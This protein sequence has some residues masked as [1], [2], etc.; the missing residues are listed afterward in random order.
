MRRYKWWL[1]MMLVLH[2][3]HAPHIILLAIGTTVLAAAPTLAWSAAIFTAIAAVYLPTFRG[4]P[5]ST[6]LRSWG[7]FQVWATRVVEDAAR[8]WHGECR[9]VRDGP[10]WQFDRSSAGKAGQAQGEEEGQGRGFEAGPGE[11]GRG[12]VGQERG[13]VEEVEG[14]GG[15]EGG[16]EDAEGEGGT[17]PGASGMKGVRRLVFGYHPHGMMPAAACWFHLTPQFAALFPSVPSPVTLGASVIFRVPIL[18]D[19]VMW[20]GARAV[21]R[22]VFQAALRERGAVVLCPGGQAELVVGTVQYRCPRHQT[23][24]QHSFLEL[25]DT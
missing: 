5:D 14:S 18:R 16:A 15:G 4:R 22:A 8:R 19:V 25:N 17:S 11:A 12:E 1:E 6:G 23:H 24:F 2:V 13:G 20:S 21:T 10:A 3:I 7:A 9:V